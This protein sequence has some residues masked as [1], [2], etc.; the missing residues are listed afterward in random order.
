MDILVIAIQ[1]MIFHM[2]YHIQNICILI[3]KMS[4]ISDETKL[5]LGY[6]LGDLILGTS[7]SQ[8]MYQEKGG[9][10]LS[11]VEG[12]TSYDFKILKLRY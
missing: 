4:Q 11:Y 1:L 7:Y 6:T 8:A 5:A 10:K 12:T 2:I 9:D 3:Q